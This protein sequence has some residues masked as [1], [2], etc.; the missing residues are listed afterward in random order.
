MRPA[1]RRLNSKLGQAAQKYI[2]NLESNIKRHRLIERAGEAHELSTSDEEAERKLQA[3]DIE[4]KNYMRCAEAK[5][6]R[7]KS[8]RIP[9]SP[10]AVEWILKKQV[11]QTLLKGK[12]GWKI[13]KGNLR[14][15]ARRCKVAGSFRLTAQ[16]I[17]HKLEESKEKCHYFLKHGKRYRRKHLHRR[18]RVAR[19]KEDT[20][21]ERRILEII[22]REK[23]KQF[24]R[25]LRYALGKVRG[26]SVSEVHIQHEG[27]TI[28]IKN[29]DKLHQ[30]IWEEVHKKRFHLAEQAPICSG[31]L[32]GDFGYLANTSA[33]EHALEGTYEFPNG[34]HEAT[35]DLLD[36][37]ARI[38]K[39][40]PK[41]SV[42]DIITKE[43]WQSRW[44]KSE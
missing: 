39:L 24:W 25:R 12:A 38:R 42:P 14:R 10:E 29:R 6:R 5:C 18:L 3:L 1:T 36:E 4:R 26:G 20:E 32:R 23:D 31:Q 27:Q 7:I 44:K 11:Y 2:A 19:D 43:M 34:R 41:N 22:Q 40:I 8:G 30:A 17:Y 28:A 37:I 35:K 13:N 15:K 16:E 33:A 21:A 9:Y